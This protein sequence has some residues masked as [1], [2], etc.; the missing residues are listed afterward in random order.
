MKAVK[1]QSNHKKTSD[2]SIQKVN[3]SHSPKVMRVKD[4]TATDWRNKEDTTRKCTG[5]LEL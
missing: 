2:K 3:V 4:R 1:V 5:G